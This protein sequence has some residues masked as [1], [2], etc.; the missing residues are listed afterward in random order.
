[1]SWDHDIRKINCPCGQGTIEREIKSDDWNRIEE[2]P[3]KINCSNCSKKYNLVSLSCWS[4]NNGY[5][6]IDYLVPKEVDLSVNRE[7][8]YQRVDVYELFR[9][10]FAHALICSYELDW[11]KEAYDELNNKTSVATLKGYASSIADKRKKYLKTAKLKDI[12]SDVLVAINDYEN[13]FINKKQ[14]D[15]QTE[16]DRK[17]EQEFREKVK[18]NGIILNI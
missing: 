1:M 11:L 13:Y 10:D 14:I 5:F 7:Q 4:Q 8:K 9:K 16:I 12:K 18:I 2:G 3:V 6:T 15:E 17:A